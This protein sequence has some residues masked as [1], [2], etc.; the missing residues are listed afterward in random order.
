MGRPKKQLQNNKTTSSKVKPLKKISSEE[1]LK[2][3]KQDNKPTEKL[4]CMC[5]GKK[6]QDNFYMSHNIF[7]KYY[8]VIPYCKTCIRGIMWDYYLKKHN[9]DEQLALHGLLRSLNLPYIHSLYISSI[10][11]I[12]NPNSKI[13]NVHKIEETDEETEEEIEDRYNKNTINK[14][15]NSVIVAAYMKN[16]NS[17]HDSNNYGDTYLDSVGLEEVVGLKSY[18]DI[19]R[20]K[21]K[22]QADSIQKEKAEKYEELRYDVDDLIY[23]WGEFDEETLIKLELEWLDWS[24]KIGDYI[25]EKSTQLILKQIC[26]LTVE[27]ENKRLRGEK[28]KDE[29]SSLQVLMKESNLIEKQQ[30]NEGEKL[31]IGMKIKEIEY[32]RPIKSAIPSL[33]DVDHYGEIINTFIGNTSKTLGM[34]NEYTKKC[35]E[36]YKKY[37]IDMNKLNIA[38]VCN[39][40][41]SQQDKKEDG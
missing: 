16:Y 29:I 20:V 27:I 19:V 23:K 1:L 21:R 28:V 2:N 30:R 32:S 39:N 18:N 6:T 15:N 9:G 40:E 24:D 4:S 34:E 17:L 13:N 10:K 25:Y 35:D 7:D 11:T 14:E 33:V 38:T 5:C 26:F 37:T 36:I 8:K 22:K 12:N 3:P 41:E 31:I